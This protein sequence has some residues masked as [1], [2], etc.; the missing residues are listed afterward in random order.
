M[1]RT[2]LFVLPK[3]NTIL[4]RP[5]KSANSVKEKEWL[6]LW[7]NNNQDRIFT[8]LEFQVLMVQNFHKPDAQFINEN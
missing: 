7:D 8:S 5:K 2:R 6:E 4:Q 3:R 1:I